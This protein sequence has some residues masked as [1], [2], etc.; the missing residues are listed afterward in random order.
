MAGGGVGER[1]ES[2]VGVQKRPVT[3]C[4]GEHVQHLG[5]PSWRGTFLLPQGYQVL[6]IQARPSRGHVCTG[7]AGM[8]ESNSG[9]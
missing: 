3:L 2:S 8:R 6:Q 1:A 7:Q 9:Q 4:T 5:T